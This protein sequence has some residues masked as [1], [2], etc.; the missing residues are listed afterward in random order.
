MCWVITS[1]KLAVVQCESSVGGSPRT[2][3]RITPPF[4]GTWASATVPSVTKAVSTRARAAI[5]PVSL[6]ADLLG[7][8]RARPGAGPEGA[9]ID[10]DRRGDGD[11][12][13]GGERGDGELGLT[14]GPLDPHLRRG[15]H[16][17][18]VR[19]P[20]AHA[21]QVVV[22]AVEARRRIEL[23]VLLLGALGG[24][25]LPPQLAPRL[26]ALGAAAVGP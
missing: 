15:L 26:P 11:V 9:A 2:A 8:A 21:G 12:V 16:A 19:A 3:T 24:H 17:G 1:T 14:D 7:R 25:H 23:L 13:R 22:P 4:F 10:R 20:G 18:G 5:R 6:I